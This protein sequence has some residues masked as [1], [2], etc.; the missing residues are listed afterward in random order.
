LILLI[1]LIDRC[2]TIETI[3]W[4]NAVHSCCLGKR[5]WLVPAILVQCSS[6]SLNTVD[7]WRS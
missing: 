1:Q 4:I 7:K 6:M 3:S 5:P 2:T